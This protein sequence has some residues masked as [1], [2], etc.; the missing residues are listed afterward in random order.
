MI[1]NLEL[2]LGVVPS[3]SARPLK[4]LVA[5]VVLTAASLHAQQQV[6]VVNGASFRTETT[7]GAWATAGGNFAGVTNATATTLPIPK[8]LNGVTVT[9]DGVDAPVYFVS[10]TQ[11]N[12][13]I[14]YE[15]QPGVRPVA[16]KTPTVTLNGTVRVLKAAP[17]IFV[18]DAS[19]PPKG[20]IL[21]QNSS[22]NSSGNAARRG[23][24]IQI[25]GTGAGRF[26]GAV[27]DGAAAEGLISSISTPQVFIGGVAARVQF[28]GLTPGLTG[29]WQVNAFVPENAFLTGRVPVQV[30]IDGLDSNEAGLF[31]Q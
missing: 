5:A 27:V 16:V 17:A 19:T 22:L 1:H 11:I 26:Q 30:F 29:V 20:A 21:N 9:V 12:F 15:T 10:A 3:L 8:T 18:Q 25:Y 23:E 2:F 7:G 13:L 24:V 6:T 14:P 28:S 4:S 31:V